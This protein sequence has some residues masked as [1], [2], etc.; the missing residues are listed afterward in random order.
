MVDASTGTGEAV[1]AST[2]ADAMMTKPPRI[3]GGRPQRSD[4]RPK[5]TPPQTEARPIREEIRLVVEEAQP[6]SWS[7]VTKK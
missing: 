7:W 3:S 1:S 2:G 6:A 5:S 4:S